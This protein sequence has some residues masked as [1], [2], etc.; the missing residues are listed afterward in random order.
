M[1][2]KTRASRTVLEDCKTAAAEM[3]DGISG[4]AWRWRWVAIV[5]LLRAVGHVLS[6]EAEQ[7]APP[8]RAAAAAWWKALKASKPRPP[9]FWEFIE[10]ARNDAVKE[11][12][13]HAGQGVTVFAQAAVGGW[14]VSAPGEEVEFTEPPPMPPPR[15]PEYCYPM[16][17]GPFAGRDQREVIAE[18]IAWWQDQLDAI[19]ADAAA[20]EQ[21]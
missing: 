3:T 20:R 11:Y 18:A 1:L 15:S 17:R 5:A 19:D 14:A 13:L 9:I 7:G 10:E 12:V 2:E 8:F 21:A 4:P 16:T 6:A